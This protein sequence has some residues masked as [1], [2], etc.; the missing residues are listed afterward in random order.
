[1]FKASLY[2]P[3]TSSQFYKMY[4]NI[5]VELDHDYCINLSKFNFKLNLEGARTKR[6]AKSGFS[7]W[8]TDIAEF[9]KLCYFSSIVNVRR[10][11]GTKT[12]DNL[13]GTIP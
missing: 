11:N 7:R 8:R 4:L 9:T 6:E 10:V 2:R 13:A 5:L 1:M 12:Y 3:F